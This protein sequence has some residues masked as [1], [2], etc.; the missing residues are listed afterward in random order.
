MPMFMS[1][2]KGMMMIYTVSLTT[3]HISIILTQAKKVQTDS[4][5]NYVSY[6][7]KKKKKKE[8]WALLRRQ[9]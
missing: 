8:N 6:F 7:E 4:R 9:F 2:L 3:R 5:C 1:L